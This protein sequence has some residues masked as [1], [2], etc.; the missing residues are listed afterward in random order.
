MAAP[1]HDMAALAGSMRTTPLFT[2]ILPP[3]IASI[4]HEELVKWKRE[5]REHE[6]KLRGRCR[7]SGEVYIA[8]EYVIDAFESDLFDVFCDLKLQILVAEVA[9]GVL[10]AD[11]K[12]TEDN[13]KNNTLPEIKTLF[14]KH[15]KISMGESDVKARIFDYF[16]IFSRIT[17]SQREADGVREKCKRLMLSLQP[18]TLKQEV[19]LCQV[20]ERNDNQYEHSSA[21]ATANASKPTVKPLGPCPKCKEMHWLHECIQVIEDKKEDLFQ[22]LRDPKKAKESRPKHELTEI[23]CQYK[24]CYKD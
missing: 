19:K 18:S 3:R 6:A 12:H 17:G 14:K 13:V 22:R 24:I 5:R 4:F 16:R 11:I 8:V 7:V 23:Y 10:V 9:E 1:A 21:K 20:I 15:L 2:P